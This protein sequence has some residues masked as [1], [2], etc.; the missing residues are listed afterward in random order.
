VASA[1]DSVKLKTALLNSVQY[2]QNSALPVDPPYAIGVFP[3]YISGSPKIGI[4]LVGVMWL[5]TADY[6]VDLDTTMAQ[7]VIS[8]NTNTPLG[9]IPLL[10]FPFDNSAGFVASWNIGLQVFSISAPVGSG[11]TYG[12][13][14]VQFAYSGGSMGGGAGSAANFPNG[15]NACDLAIYPAAGENIYGSALNVPMV[16]VPGQQIKFV[17]ANGGEWRIS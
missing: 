10:G 4:Y 1:N 14:A 8:V 12:G 5:G 3:T 9:T 15:V 17:S 13:A 2:V 11:D 6:A 7:L 16:I